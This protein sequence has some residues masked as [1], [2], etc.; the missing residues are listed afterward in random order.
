MQS[1]KL[2]V[3]YKKINFVVGKVFVLHILNR[4]RLLYRIIKY[5][6]NICNVQAGIYRYLNGSNILQTFSENIF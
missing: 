6:R 4:S 5:R 1:S 3:F 2:C